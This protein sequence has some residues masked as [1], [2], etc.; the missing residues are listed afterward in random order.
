[1]AT[2]GLDEVR[3]RLRDQLRLR[4]AALHA[5]VPRHETL[6]RVY[7]WSYELLS[8]VEQAVFRRLEPFLGGFRTELAEQVASDEAGAGPVD[9][10]R[11]LDAIAALVDKSLVQRGPEGS[12]R[13][14]LLESAR[15]YARERLVEANETDAVNRRFARAIAQRFAHALGDGDRLTD[16]QWL[17]KY[18]PERDNARAALALA[19]REHMADELASLVTALSMMDL[20]LCRQPEIMQCDV[21]MAVLAE[22]APPLRAAAYL[23]LS[24]VHY[25]DGDRDIGATLAEEAFRLYTALG[26]PARAY[27]A[28]A[29]LTRLNEARPG[30]AE[31]AQSAWTQLESFDD[32]DVPLRTR[33]FCAISCGLMNRPGLT[34]ER[35]QELGR[36]AEEAGFAAIAA[37]CDCNL[38]D[39][40]LIAGR[41]AEA[42]R[43]ADH[44][45]Q[46]SVRPHRARAFILHNKAVA[47]I[48]M[49]RSGE[50]YALARQAFQA[51]PG[52]AHF[53]VDT[54]A[55]A[56]VRE[57][58]FA[59]AAILHGCGVRIREGLREKPDVSEAAAIAETAQG[60]QE[61]LG[62]LQ[63][64]ELMELGA[65]MSATDVLAIKVFPREQRPGATA[66]APAAARDRSSSLGVS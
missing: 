52:V 34:I 43:V 17:R 49:D 51:M 39:K 62:A 56:A 60:L 25:S 5:A 54:F 58:R 59:D 24:W 13:L 18:A 14:F 19:G 55:L 10:W 32:G 53:L 7:D 30:R 3:R 26:E 20:F 45:L 15:D 28:L 47:L 61:A 44:L 11:T 27:R 46:A 29:Q 41:N 9:A 8:P 40:L 36:L 31:A 1:V 23:E 33:L 65:A 42:L 38:T 4:A 6:Q 21:P 22:A 50:A 37:I 35:M 64:A 48:R 12:G 57:G 16:E 2:F 66:A 63:L